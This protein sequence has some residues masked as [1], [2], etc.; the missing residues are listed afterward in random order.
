MVVDHRNAS[1]D[2]QQ[3]H[4]SA[5]TDSYT[6]ACALRYALLSS[7]AGKSL[8]TSGQDLLL[9]GTQ[10]SL[11]LCMPYP[12]YPFIQHQAMLTQSYI[13]SKINEREA[14][15]TSAATEK[16]LIAGVRGHVMAKFSGCVSDI[17]LTEIPNSLNANDV[18]A[19]RAALKNKFDVDKDSHVRATA[20][21]TTSMVISS[22]LK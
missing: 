8:P 17:I 15:L 6:S 2:K 13:M 7:C 19:D 1:F 10:N 11:L 18:T 16:S 3:Q 21:T 12:H 4:I 9:L 22:T 14:A 20:I 5:N